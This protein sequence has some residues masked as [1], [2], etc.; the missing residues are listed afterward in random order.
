MSVVDESGESCGNFKREDERVAEFRKCRWNV[1]EYNDRSSRISPLAV[2]WIYILERK[3]SEAFTWVYLACFIF[4]WFFFVD[5]NFGRFSMTLKTRNKLNK[6]LNVDEA[7]LNDSSWVE[8]ENVKILFIL[9]RCEMDGSLMKAH[10]HRL[11]LSFINCEINQII[12]RAP[13]FSLMENR[14]HPPGTE[15]CFN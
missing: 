5:E 6:S 3:S 14:H 13:S 10:Q 7:R 9:K 15:C 8:N 12:F 11:Q 2:T 1:I 4:M